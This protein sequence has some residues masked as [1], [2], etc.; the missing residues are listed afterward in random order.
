MNSASVSGSVSSPADG[1][2]L[3]EDRAFHRAD[4]QTD[5]AINAGVE[6]DAVVLQTL[7]I[8]AGPG[9]DAGHRAGLN[10][11]GHTHADLGDDAVGHQAAGNKSNA[12]QPAT[13]PRD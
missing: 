8:A 11:I 9:M 2:L 1:P 12:T 10:T 4:L 7:L 3:G 5:P 6:I 13:P